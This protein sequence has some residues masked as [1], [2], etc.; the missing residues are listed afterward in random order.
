M[1]DD[2]YKSI[3][4]A[5]GAGYYNMAHS[6]NEIVTTQPEM[7]VNGTLKEYQVGLNHWNCGVMVHLLDSQFEGT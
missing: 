2:E 1:G 4:Q 7:L 3:E 6:I 5:G